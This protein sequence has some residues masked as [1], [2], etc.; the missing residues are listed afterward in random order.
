MSSKNSTTVVVSEL[1]NG[2]SAEDVYVNYGEKIPSFPKLTPR[3]DDDPYYFKGWYY[4]NTSGKLKQ[5]TVDTVFN[6][7][8]I[9]CGSSH[10]ITLYARCA[11]VWVGPH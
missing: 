11:S 1:A 9:Q 5:V 7:K 8:N 3:A 10:E 4:R 6:E 2:G